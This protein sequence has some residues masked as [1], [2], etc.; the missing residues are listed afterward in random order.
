MLLNI[1]FKFAQK[2]VKKYGLKYL[3]L[4]DNS[5]KICKNTSI[6]LA[7]MNAFLS[8]NT[9]YSKRGLLPKKQNEYAV[10]M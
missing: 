3:T 1:A 9:W 10:D 7:L 5:Q 4:Q 2:L 6:S 8:G